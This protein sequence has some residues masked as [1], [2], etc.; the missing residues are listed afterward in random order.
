[1]IYVFSSTSSCA[2]LPILMRRANRYADRISL[3]I[4]LFMIWLQLRHTYLRVLHPLL[5]KTQL[6]DVPYKRSQIVYLLESLLKNSDIREV[7]PTTKRLVER[8]LAGDWCVNL[9]RVHIML[10]DEGRGSPTSES[11]AM[12]PS[13]QEFAGT[14]S[15]A[16]LARTNSKTL[17]S[18]RSAENLK[19]R[20]R[21]PRPPRSPL[22]NVRR[23][24]STT[25]SADAV[26]PDQ[27][28]PKRKGTASSVK[29][30]GVFADR[31]HQ[32]P[33]SESEF[34]HHHHHQL[35]PSMMSASTRGRAGLQ[36][37]PDTVSH[38]LSEASASISPP[39]RRSA[40]PPPVKRRKPPAIP[41]A[42][43]NGGATFQ[44]IRTSATSPL[45][46]GTTRSPNS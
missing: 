32:F 7:T 1:M 17:K 22:D 21:P 25:G 18:S 35:I 26:I 30:E 2:S 46:K 34:H 31:H 5:T 16:Q 36:A 10:D 24:S 20:Q 37:Y 29:V 23:P 44:T 43:T 41:V 9:R 11:S 38:T 40:P 6:R 12:S 15:S 27:V 45:A 8:C 28:P 13:H 14:A 3:T 19:T 39:H 33:R 4:I 42:Q